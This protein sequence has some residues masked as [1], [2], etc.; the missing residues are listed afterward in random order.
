MLLKFKPF[1]GPL[2]Y[3]FKDPDTGFLFEAVNEAEL[4]ARIRSYRSQNNLEALDFLEATLE[5]YLCRQPENVGG[6]CPRGADLKRG[7]FQYVKG[8]IV[9][10]KRMLYSEFA[11]QEVAD[12][13][14]AQCAKCPFNV[15]P[16]KGKFL[17][18][19]DEV[20]EATVEG[21]KSSHNDEL[22]SCEVCTCTLKPKVFYIG[23]EKFTG[24]QREKMKSVNCWQLQL[25]Q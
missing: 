8:G 20:A 14:S 15:F 19:S 9:L 2:N 11:S 5:N 13:R 16:D 7:I 1:C 24:V 3:S 21:R 10:L 23:K 12:E 4:L 17:K 22:G 6:C 25:K 18:W